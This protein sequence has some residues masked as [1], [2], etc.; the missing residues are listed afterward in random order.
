M[1]PEVILPFAISTF[2]ASSQ[3]IKLLIP[4]Q[5]VCGFFYSFQ[6]P[7]TLGDLLR[8]PGRSPGWQVLFQIYFYLRS[9]PPYSGIPRSPTGDPDYLV[10]RLLGLCLTQFE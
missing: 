10:R 9:V 3:N 5:V 1:A 4:T 8:L 6:P 2:A 7:L